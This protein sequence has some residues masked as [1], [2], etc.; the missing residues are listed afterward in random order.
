MCQ[1]KIDFETIAY[2][3]Y[4]HQSHYALVLLIDD[5]NSSKNPCLKYNDVCDFL[6]KYSWF[7]IHDAQAEHGMK[8]FTKEKFRTNSLGECLTLISLGH[9]TNTGCWILKTASAAA[10]HIISSHSSL[11]RVSTITF[12]LHNNLSRET[13]LDSLWPHFSAVAATTICSSVMFLLNFLHSLL[14]ACWQLA[15]LLA[16]LQLWWSTSHLQLSFVIFKY[17]QEVWNGGVSCVWLHGHSVYSVMS[18]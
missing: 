1:L 11:L 12:N 18:F 9:Q 8:I 13:C 3:V 10:L 7:M 5:L 2:S 15:W 6:K 4:V 17:I 14:D 16:I